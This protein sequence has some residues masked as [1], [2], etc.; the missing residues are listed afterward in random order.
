MKRLLILLLPIFVTCGPSEEEVQNRIDEA[1]KSVTSKS[2]K[3]FL[4]RIIGIGPRKG[5]KFKVECEKILKPFFEAISRASTESIYS[6]GYSLAKSLIT[7]FLKA[8]K[9]EEVSVNF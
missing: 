5:K 4:E 6:T 8:R 9:P 2:K 3:V 1:V 7:G